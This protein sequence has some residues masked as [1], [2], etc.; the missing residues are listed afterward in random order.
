MPENNGNNRVTL[1]VLNTKL[2]GISADI[3][4]IKDELKRLNNHELRLQPLESYVADC[5][6]GQRVLRD[7]AIRYL[8]GG[9]GFVGLVTWIISLV[10]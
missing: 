2:E 10:R 3:G 8:V 9:G 7:T 6:D 4:D 5:K 1:A